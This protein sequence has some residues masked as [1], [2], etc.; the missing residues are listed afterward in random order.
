M[1]TM[2]CHDC[3]TAVAQS[4]RSCPLCGS[5]YPA[6]PHRRARRAPRIGVEQRNDRC[7]AAS[8]IS[9]GTLAAC[10]GFATSSSPFGAVVAVLVYG[11]GGMIAGVPV[12]F[13]INIIRG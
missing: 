4:A 6:G 2:A 8:V 5:R 1:A 12:G 13:A 7:F 9:L 3:G 11:V 10:Y